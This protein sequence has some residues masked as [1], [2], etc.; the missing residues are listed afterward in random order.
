MKKFQA[1]ITIEADSL[2]DAERIL[3][4]RIEHDEEYDGVGDYTIYSEY[5]DGA[6]TTLQEVD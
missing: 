1:V 5:K 6:Y 4:E 2:E 3:G